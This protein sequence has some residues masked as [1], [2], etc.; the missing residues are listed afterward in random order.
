MNPLPLFDAPVIHPVTESPVHSVHA[1]AKVME[2]TPVK[3]RREGHR[4]AKLGAAGLHRGV[5]RAYREFGPL[6]D[7]EVA[8]L[9]QVERTT[10]T[11]R[12]NELIELGQ[13]EEKGERKNLRTGV[14]NTTWGLKDQAKVITEAQAKV[15]NYIAEKQTGHGGATNA[16]RTP[17][18]DALGGA[19][20]ADSVVYPTDRERR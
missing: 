14:M 5:L 2:T 13:V 15:V 19:S 8:E 20:M 1:T 3:T 7:A 4:A 17:D 10:I 16:I 18:H 12:R 9:L 6:T 11:G